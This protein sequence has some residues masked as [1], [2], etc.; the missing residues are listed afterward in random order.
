MKTLLLIALLAFAAAGCASN[1]GSAD[2]RH[3][4]LRDAKQGTAYPAPDPSEPVRKPLH[5]H[6]EMK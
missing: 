4:H 5:D 6:R 2:P 1:G 3:D